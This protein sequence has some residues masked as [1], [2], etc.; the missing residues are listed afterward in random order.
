[1]LIGPGFPLLGDEKFWNQRVGMVAQHCECAQ[2][3]RIV[4]FKVVKM[5]NFMLCVFYP[6][7]KEVNVSLNI[8]FCPFESMR[9]LDLSLSIPQ[10]TGS[11]QM[12]K[13]WEVVLLSTFMATW[14]ILWPVPLILSWL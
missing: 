14:A 13:S 2:C 7:E 12:W 10:M 5:V 9:G 6:N 3:P 8:L 4:H 1:M 11:W